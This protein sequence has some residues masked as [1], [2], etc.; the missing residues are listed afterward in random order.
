MVPVVGLVML[1]DVFD[2]VCGARWPWGKRSKSTIEKPA[3][4]FRSV[5]T[6]GVLANIVV[7]CWKVEAVCQKKGIQVVCRFG[8]EDPLSPI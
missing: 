4:Y 5:I 3:Q 2:L 7:Q 6:Y 1:S 8:F